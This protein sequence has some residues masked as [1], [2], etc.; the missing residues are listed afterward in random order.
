MEGSS[1]GLISAGESLSACRHDSEW[2]LL[3]ETISTW[4]NRL[5]SN[6]GVKLSDPHAEKQFTRKKCKLLAFSVVSFPFLIWSERWSFELCAGLVLKLLP[7]HPHKTSVASSVLQTWRWWWCLRFC[8]IS[9]TFV[10]EALLQATY[11]VLAAMKLK[12][13]DLSCSRGSCACPLDV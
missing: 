10:R 9:T 1:R 2:R 5:S 4:G 3:S 6:T 13:W 12:A 11:C 8:L 7:S